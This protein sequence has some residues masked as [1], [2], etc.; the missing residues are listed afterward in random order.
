M[1]SVDTRLP[2]PSHVTI[3]IRLIDRPPL[4]SA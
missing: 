2:A 4:V 3:R 1:P